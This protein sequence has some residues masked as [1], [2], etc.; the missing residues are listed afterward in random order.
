MEK[1]ISN[2]NYNSLFFFVRK[3]FFIFIMLRRPVNL[4]H[5]FESYTTQ[6]HNSQF[7]TGIIKISNVKPQCANV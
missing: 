1:T 4:I 2:L 5:E 7:S 6:Y 3:L